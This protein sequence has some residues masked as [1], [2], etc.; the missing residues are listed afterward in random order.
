MIE[1]VC[2]ITQSCSLFALL[3]V[4]D[5][6]LEEAFTGKSTT[7]CLPSVGDWVVVIATALISVTELFVQLPLG[8]THPLRLAKDNEKSSGKHCAHVYCIA[9]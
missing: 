7:L 6:Q 5:S 1:S 4:C 2:S 3:G 9:G 8:C